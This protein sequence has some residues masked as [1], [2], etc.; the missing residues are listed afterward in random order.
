MLYAL[1]KIPARIAF[2][3]YCRHLSVTKKALLKSKGPLLIAANHPNSFLDAVIL[4]TIFQQPIYSLAR[5][6]VFTNKFNTLILR[7]LNILPIYRLSEGAENIERNYSSFDACK[8]IFKNN[9]IV[10][11]FSEGSCSNEWKLRPL[12]KGTARLAI[13]AWQDNIPLKVL[14]V[15]INY[16]SFHSFGKNIQLNLGEII[17]K[18]TIEL[19][20]GFGKSIASFNDKLQTALQPLVIEIDSNDKAAINKTFTYKITAIKKTLLFI[21][22]IFGWILHAPFY[23]PL[24]KIAWKLNTHKDHFDSVLIGFLFFSYPFYLLLLSLITYWIAGWWC[25]LVFIIVPF[26]GW[27]TVQLSERRFV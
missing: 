22:S 10:L 1:L 23:Y 20:D 14:P 11:I 13:N 15:G 7:S 21:P 18:E 3:I 12:K 4:A 16:S 6:D 27:S 2:W 17:T 9:G 26:F 25:L 8:K 24:K 5:G 19:N